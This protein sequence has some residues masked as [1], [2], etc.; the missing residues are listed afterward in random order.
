M[1]NIKFYSS[2]LLSCLRDERVKEKHIAKLEKENYT[3]NFIDFNTML[4]VI[5]ACDN[6]TDHGFVN[7]VDTEVVDSEVGFWSLIRGIVPGK[8]FL[9]EN[10]LTYFFKVRFGVALT[11]LLKA[12]IVWDQIIEWTGFST[13]KQ[14]I[15]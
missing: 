15:L 13:M 9:S 5:D 14:L 7:R 12:I 4:V 1:S 3:V 6:M 2:C 11:I 10:H 8:I